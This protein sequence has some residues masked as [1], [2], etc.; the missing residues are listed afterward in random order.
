[1]PNRYLL[2]TNILSDILK[3]PQ[4]KA[5]H[6]ISSFSSQERD[7]LATSIIVAA[8]LRYG[9]T[10]SGS[11]M[12]AERVDQLLEAIEILPLEPK[13]VRHYGQIRARLERAGTPIGAND[14]LIAAHAFAIDATLVTDNLREFRRVK[15][16]KLEN[17]LRS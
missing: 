14:L 3:H 6:K 11:S 7:L 2:D 12:L 8:E 1:V 10:K 15:G 9:A 17:W 13:A 5:A 4:G 16:L